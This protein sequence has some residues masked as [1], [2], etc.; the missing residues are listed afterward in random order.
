[1]SD[2]ILRISDLTKDFPVGQ[3]KFGGPRHH[4][5]AV[6]SV[7]F[8]VGRGETLGIVGESGCGKTTLGRLV[9]RLLEPSGGRIEFE[10]RDITHL[11]ERE[12]RPIRQHLQVVFQDPYSSLNPRMQVRD[13]IGEPLG[14]FG[15]SPKQITQRVAEV[16]EIVGLPADYMSRHPHAFS[17][18][19]RQ[20]IGIAR[21][22]A[23]QPRLIV[24]DEAVSALD[25]SIQAQILNLL[26]DIQRQF[27]L[28]LVFISHNL[29]VIRHV[30]HR[31]AVM[32]LGQIVELAE[33]N[34]LFTTPLHPYT[35]ALISAVPE[36]DPD[37]ESEHVPLQGEIPSPVN[38]PSGCYFHT[39]CPVAQDRCRVEMPEIS[40]ISP[41]RQVRCHYPGTAIE[42]ST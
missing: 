28:S 42:D 18:G 13:I 26:V 14:N 24:C 20:R 31:I 9:L 8:D 23:L 35:H 32:Y 27:D 5:R 33:E 19:Q 12:M 3:R 37:S 11:T 7:T 36:P 41:G 10:N 6:D 4:L 38:P 25:V 30:S 16:M 2:P 22:L 34:D 15:H 17:G 39:R 1:M 40:R 21:A 29:G